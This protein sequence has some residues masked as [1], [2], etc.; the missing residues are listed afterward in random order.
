MRRIVTCVPIV[1]A[2]MLFGSP[3]KAQVDRATLSGF[4]RD[5]SGGVLP[6]ATVTATNTATGVAQEQATLRPGRT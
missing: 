1:G 6:G 5:S 3:A 2:L 4:V